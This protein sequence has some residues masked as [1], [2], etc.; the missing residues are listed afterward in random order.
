MSTFRRL[1]AVGLAAGVVLGLSG[2]STIEKV[3]SAMSSAQ[4]AA[5]ADISQWTADK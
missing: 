2:C 1:T 4:A 5:S 3:Q